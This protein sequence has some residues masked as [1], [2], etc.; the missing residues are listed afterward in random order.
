MT[1]TVYP[2]PDAALM[3]P[4]VA[5]LLLH[6][7]KN[8]NMDSKGHSH[9]HTGKSIGDGAQLLDFRKVQPY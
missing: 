6:P 3:K 7:Q 5:P 4:V 1:K 2:S 9:Q 8:I